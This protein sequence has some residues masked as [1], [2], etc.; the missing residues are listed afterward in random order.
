MSEEELAE[1]RQ[2]W[3]NLPKAIRR[4]IMRE[5]LHCENEENANKMKHFIIDKRDE[6]KIPRYSK[7]DFLER[8]IFGMA[9]FD[10]LFDRD[11]FPRYCGLIKVL[12]VSPTR[13][14]D[15]ELDEGDYVSVTT[16]T[17]HI[18]QRIIQR[19]IIHLQKGTV[20]DY[21]ELIYDIA[22]SFN[23]ELGSIKGD[24]A[25]IMSQTAEVIGVPVFLLPFD[26][27]GASECI[28]STIEFCHEDYGV[29]SCSNGNWPHS[30]IY[31]MATWM[32]GCNDGETDDGST[33]WTIRGDIDE[34]EHV[35]TFEKKS[36]AKRFWSQL[37]E[38]DKPKFVL[39]VTGGF[40]SHDFFK[41]RKFLCLAKMATG[42]NEEEWEMHGSSDCD[43]RGLLI[44]YQLE[45]NQ[46][47]SQYPNNHVL[48][49]M[50]M[51]GPFPQECEYITFVTNEKLHLK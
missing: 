38:E 44:L 37:R 1:A 29:T 6:L 36:L 47:L 25:Q 14:E 15:G 33:K 7:L 16:R 51:L 26:K 18:M 42:C 40:P 13:G 46:H 5:E 24:M 50:N 3:N 20:G 17:A 48:M 23:L 31:D 19:S 32:Y 10:T 27:G 21:R 2:L 35:I 4:T 11:I 8:L 49:T 28:F 34:V 22:D 41:M 43:P 9:N 45:A 30:G 39:L 12:K